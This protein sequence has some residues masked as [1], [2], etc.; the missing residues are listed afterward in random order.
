MLINCFIKATICSLNNIKFT[1]N[2][3][4]KDWKLSLKKNRKTN[5]FAQKKKKNFLIV[6]TNK[7]VVSIQLYSLENYWREKTEDEQKMKL[8]GL[9]YHLPNFSL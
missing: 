1:A 9:Q 7:S 6:Q 8:F 2:K 5:R 3:C 4:Q